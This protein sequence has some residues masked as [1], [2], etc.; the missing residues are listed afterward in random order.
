MI[1]GMKTIS[2]ETNTKGNVF[3]HHQQMYNFLLSADD[4]QRIVIFGTAPGAILS[5]RSF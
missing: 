3:I 5:V 2:I 1:T 4:A